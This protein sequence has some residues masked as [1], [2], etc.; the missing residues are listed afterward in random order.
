MEEVKIAIA[1]LTSS[2]LSVSSLEQFHSVSDVELRPDD[3]ALSLV[4]LPTEA[5]M[6]RRGMDALG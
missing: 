4:G 1:I 3:L 5:F 6:L 2:I